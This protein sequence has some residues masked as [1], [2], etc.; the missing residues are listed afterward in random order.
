MKVRNGFVS[1]SSSSSFIIYKKDEEMGFE[2]REAKTIEALKKYRDP[3]DDEERESNKKE[4][5]RLSE[6]GKYIIAKM[7]VEWGGEEAV[8]NIIPV[9]LKS[10]GVDENVISYEWGE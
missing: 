8:E 3:Y 9:I 5:F 2:E 10:L 6:E 1:N 4:A 7:N